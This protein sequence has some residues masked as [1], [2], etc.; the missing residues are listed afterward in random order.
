[1]LRPVAMPADPGAGIVADQQRGPERSRVHPDLRREVLA[2]REQP[3][4]QRRS[5]A[6]AAAREVVGRS[7]VRRQA[8]AA[9]LAELERGKRRGVDPGGEP[10]FCFGRHRF[11]HQPEARD[12]RQSCGKQFALDRH[13]PLYREAMKQALETLTIHTGGAGLHEIT[14]DIAAWLSGT[15]L[16]SGVATLF[17][18]H[19]SAGLLITENASPAVQRDLMRWLATTAPESRSYEHDC[20]GPDDM[21]A[22]LKSVLTGNSLTVPVS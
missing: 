4:R 2:Q 17:C 3:V 22:H 19:T 16:D 7:V 1:V 20:E 21:P 12:R 18:R 9:P 8:L 5:L 14:D 6:D 15:G 13:V 10:G 11:G